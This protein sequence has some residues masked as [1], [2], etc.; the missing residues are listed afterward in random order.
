MKY[1]PQELEKLMEFFKKFPGIGEKSSERLALAVLDMPEDYLQ[2]IA[3]SLVKAKKNLHSCSICGHLT[4][5]EICTICSNEFRNKN[6]ICVIEDYKSVFAFEKSGNYKGVYHVLNGL[7]SPMDDVGVEDINLNSLVERVEK[8]EN[9]E[10]ILALKSS[11][12]GET[13]TLYIK[14]IFEN[15]KVKISRLSYG[16]P[17]GAEID[18]LDMATLYRALEDRKIISE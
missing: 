18:Y 17:M 7:L 9:P 4:N 5:D 1:Y 6:V 12:E 8:L 13:T 16:L 2:D 14:K 10:L 11:V 3:K 15:K